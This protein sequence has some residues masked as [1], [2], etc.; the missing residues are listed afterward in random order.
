M[1]YNLIQKYEGCKLQAYKCPMGIWTIGWGNT[2]YPDGSKV[3]QGDVITK[4]YAD[5]LLTD[6]LIKNVYPVWAKIPYTLT[7]GQKDALAS[8]CYNV[9]VP[10]FL[11]SKLYTAICKKDYAEVCRQWDFGFKNNL[12]GIF[13]R[14]TE[15]LYLFIKD[16]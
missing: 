11:R 8:L 5:A 6:Y 15:E 9:G 3:K 12:K 16:I 13:K 14:R 7:Q 2:T 10:S 1:C 4:E